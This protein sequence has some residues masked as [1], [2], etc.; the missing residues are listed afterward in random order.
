MVVE[1]RFEELKVKV[2]R[3]G[4]GRLAQWV[5]ISPGEEDRTLTHFSY[6]RLKELGEGIWEMP[7]V[8]G[9]A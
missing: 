8:V 9:A 4:T 6:D 3:F 7:Q 1:I 2:R 5:I